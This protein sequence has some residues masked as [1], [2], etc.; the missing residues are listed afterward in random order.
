M[1]LNSIAEDLIYFGQ[2]VLVQLQNSLKLVPTVKRNYTGAEA[3]AGSHVQIPL[4]DIV[5]AAAVRGIGGAVTASGLNSSFVTVDMQQIYKAVSIDNLQRTFSNVD[6]FAEAAY[7][8]AYLVAAAADAQVAG[9]W[10][11]MPYEAGTTDGTSAFATTLDIDTVSTARKVLSQNQAPL[12]EPNLHFVV[13][14]TEALN[15]RKLASYK[16]MNFSGTAEGRRRGA[17]GELMG[18][19]IWESQQI[20]GPV[21]FSPTAVWGASPVVTGVNAIGATSLACSA[22]GAGTLKAGSTFTLDGFKYS[23]TADA[24]ITANAAT[25]LIYPGL[26][27]ASTVSDA[28]TPSLHTV[29]SGSVNLAYHSDGI[30]A[31]ARPSVAFAEGSG[32][33][34]VVT[35]DP[36]TGLS[37]RLSHQSILVGAAG[38]LEHLVCDLVFG[39][40]VIRPEFC[41]KVSGA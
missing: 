35:T 11:Q 28:I 6:L 20:A 38:M 4:I 34:S 10:N 2:E 9:L 25:L 17:L 30:L 13:S 33:T 8:M 31:V 22:L 1:A 5:G 16:Q 27:Q 26:K 21:T 3:A 14:P 7:R 41:V 18:F 36:Q 29:A 32:V 39:T 15:I 12:D 24:V 23:V 19:N 40:K 37:I